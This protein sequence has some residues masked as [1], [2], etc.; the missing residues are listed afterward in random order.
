MKSVLLIVIRFY[1]YMLSPWFSGCCRYEPTCSSYARQAIHAHGARK[2]L[3]LGL[4]RILRCMPGRGFGLDPV[5]PVLP[6]SEPDAMM[7]VK[8]KG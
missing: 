5:P 1:H 2:G 4:K 7:T 3:W 6:A 8:K